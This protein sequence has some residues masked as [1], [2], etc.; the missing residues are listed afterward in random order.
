MMRRKKRGE[1]DEKGSTV[2]E[3]SFKEFI[4]EQIAY[5]QHTIDEMP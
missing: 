5:L 1:K 2:Q 4:Q 3:E